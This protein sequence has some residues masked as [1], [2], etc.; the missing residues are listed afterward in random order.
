MILDQITPRQEYSITD[1]F[2]MIKISDSTLYR[3]IKR[4]DLKAFKRGGRGKWII[5][6][7]EFAEWY[8]NR[9]YANL[10]ARVNQTSSN[11]AKLRHRDT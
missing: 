6:G 1:L 8:M 11:T 7:R 10:L 5:I 4:G 2:N 9:A 3:A